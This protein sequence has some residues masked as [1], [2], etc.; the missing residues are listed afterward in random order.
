MYYYLYNH[1]LGNIIPNMNEHLARALYTIFKPLIRLMLRH[2]ISFGDVTRLLKKAYIEAT[3][4]ELVASGEK[5]T[6]SRIAIITGLTR[7]DVS[8]LRKENSPKLEH[9]TN[10]N[11]AIR[12][13]SGWISDAQYCKEDGNPKVLDIQGET[14]S[15]ETLVSRY[16][17]DIPYRAML[18]ELLRTDAVQKIADNKVE[19]VRSAYLSTEDESEKYVLLGEDVSLLIETIAHNISSDADELRYQ[20]KVLYDNIPQ[21]KLDEFKA[22]ANRENQLLLVKLNTWLAEHDMDKQNTRSSEKPMEVGVGVYYF[23]KPAIKKEDKK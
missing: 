7:K 15:F 3:E 11:R 14:G 6:T 17:G 12:V 23:E 19:L 16:S 20:R 4:A 5:V 18:K 10:H 13:I 8:A 21:D 2:G 9:S 1:Q 22:L